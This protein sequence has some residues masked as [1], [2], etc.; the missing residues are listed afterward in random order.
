MQLFAEG[1]WAVRLPCTLALFVPGLVPVLASR[2]HAPLSVATYLSA[3]SMTF[4]LRS[5]GDWFD[6]PRGALAVLVGLAVLVS[7]VTIW[8]L[9]N[10]WSAGVGGAAIGVASAWLW[11]PCVGRHLGEL[12]NRAASGGSIALLPRFGIYVGSVCAILVVISLLP[13]AWPPVA[14]IRDHARTR[15]A[16]LAIGGLLSLAIAVGMYDDI[17]AELARISLRIQ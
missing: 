8:K 9:Q 4:W 6:S 10:R 2:R 12:L 3:A 16:G 11:I 15:L 17:V 13:H 5:T 7:T 1:L 14:S